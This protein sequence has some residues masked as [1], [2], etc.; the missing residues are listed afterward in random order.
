M[1][2]ALIRRQFAALMGNSIPVP[3][4][5]TIQAPVFHCEAFSMFVRISETPTPEEIRECL[6]DSQGN[7]NVNVDPEDA[8]SPVSVIGSEAIHVGRIAADPQDP[9]V[10]GFWLTADNLRIAAANALSIAEQ[11]MLAEIPRKI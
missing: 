4:L 10:F 2:E 1:T 5:M 9:A 3:G 7:I 11:I 8:P 6:V